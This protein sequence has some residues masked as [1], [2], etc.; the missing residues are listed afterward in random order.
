V[1]YWPAIAMQI[2]GAAM[3][4]GV[5]IYEHEADRSHVQETIIASIWTLVFVVMIAA[6]LLGGQSKPIETAHIAT[7][8]EAR[9]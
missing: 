3:R 8:S 6:P 2:K 7:A 9:Q 1:D 5:R 4:R